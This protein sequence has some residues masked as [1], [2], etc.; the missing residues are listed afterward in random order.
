MIR[1]YFGYLTICLIWGSTWLALK[2]GLNSF[3]ALLGSSLRF[4]LASLILFA[5]V[6]IRKIQFPKTREERGV[7]LFSGTTSF[8]IAYGLVYLAGQFIPSSL[9][10]IMFTTYPLWVFV[11]SWVFLNESTPTFGKILGI[12]LGFLGII[13]VFGHQVQ[14]SGGNTLLGMILVFLSSGIQALNLI[15]IKKYA[16]SVSAFQ[17]NMIP[18]GIGAILQF[19]YSFLFEDWTKI[20]FDATGIAMILYLAIFGSVIVFVVYWWLLSQVTAVTLSLT[21]FITPI[22]AVVLGLTIAGEQLNFWIYF[23]GCVTLIGIAVYNYS[24][25]IFN[26]IKQKNG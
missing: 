20:N 17:L 13:L 2:I 23:G 25:K 10:S 19:V 1:I 21:A 18:M 7:I 26:S 9:S 8:G 11:F 4:G 6:K 14:W 24:D 5:I 16:P 12:L 22:I 15:G 3:P